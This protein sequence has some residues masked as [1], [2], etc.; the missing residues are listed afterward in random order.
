MSVTGLTTRPRPS[1]AR[2]ACRASAGASG[3]KSSA[4]HSPAPRTS[5]PGSPSSGSPAARRGPGGA[6][7]EAAPELP[8]PVGQPGRDLVDVAAEQRLDHVQGGQ[9]GGAGDRVAAEGGAVVAALHG[10][11]DLGPGDGGPDRVAGAERLG[12]GD[13]VGPDLV[14]LVGEEAAGA[15]HPGL[16][17]VH[18]QQHPGPRGHLPDGPQVAGGRDPDP[19]LALDRLDQHGRRVRADGRG[20]GVDVAEG[21]VGEAGGHGLERGVHG[22]LAG[23]GQGGQGA[24][25]E[26]AEG[27]HDA[28]GLLAPV[29]PAPA[30]GHLDGGLV[31]LGARS[32]TGTPWRR[33]RRG[34]P[35]ARPAPPGGR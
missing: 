11:G 8:Q 6:A 5:A 3:P 34:R 27:G 28:G 18:H 33:R 22:R 29:G 20:Q 4:N 31:G 1:A 15:A 23:G 9:G 12:H 19:G 17:L 25:V 21:H 7:G 14:V 13:H 35:G 24:A 2:A 30:P 26:A 10:L 32:W 16:D